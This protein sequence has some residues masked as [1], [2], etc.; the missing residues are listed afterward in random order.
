M[1]TT[2]CQ[3]HHPTPLYYRPVEDQSV[4]LTFILHHYADYVLCV[5]C[6][7]IGH[8]I[9][10]RRGGVRWWPKDSFFRDRMQNADAW[11]RLY[12]PVARGTK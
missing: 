1:T 9:K 12:T 6:G 8:Y 11:N 3:V 4:M 5:K 10:S 7:R 2:K